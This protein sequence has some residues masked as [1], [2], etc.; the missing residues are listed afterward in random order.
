M[1]TNKETVFPLVKWKMMTK[2]KK[3]GG[4]GLK[5]LFLFGHALASKSPWRFLF[6]NGLW[7][8]MIKLKYLKNHSVVDWCR[9]KPKNYVSTYNI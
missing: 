5:E 2:P 6:D 4:W 3:L 7:G 8:T 1:G 9:A